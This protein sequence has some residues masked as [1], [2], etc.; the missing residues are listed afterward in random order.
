MQNISFFWSTRVWTQLTT[1]L[2]VTKYAYY[3]IKCSWQYVNHFWLQLIINYLFVK[4]KIKQKIWACLMLFWREAYPSWVFE[5]R[6]K[7]D[8]TWAQ[9]GGRSHTFWW[10]S[11]MN[12]SYH[13]I[14][15]L[16]LP[17]ILAVPGWWRE[18][19]CSQRKMMKGKNW[20]K[21]EQNAGCP[22]T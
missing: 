2:R 18:K 6:W 22:A 3:L 4:S 7:Y 16:Y 15:V 9:S 5:E 8:C 1:L 17:I 12:F 13:Q 14:N 21:R 10:F 11:Q 19:T 20:I